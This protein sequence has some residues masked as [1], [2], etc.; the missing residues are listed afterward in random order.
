MFA[1]AAG[2]E[3]LFPFV[4]TDGGDIYVGDNGNFRV[5]SI[6]DAAR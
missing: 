1:L 5:R 2:F 6:A 4:I 3:R